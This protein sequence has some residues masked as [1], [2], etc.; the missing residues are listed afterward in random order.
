VEERTRQLHEETT[1]RLQVERQIAVISDREQERIGHELHDD[2]G[3][4]L[5]GVSFRMKVLENDL[6]TA[7][8]PQAADAKELG[9]LVT[10][11]IRHT[12]LLARRL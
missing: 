2:L 12:R 11:A 1:Q 9:G 3:Q 10:E 5:A 7:G 6:A 8:V 4:H